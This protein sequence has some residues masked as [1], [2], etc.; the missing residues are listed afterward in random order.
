LVRFGRYLGKFEQLWVNLL[1]LCQK[2]SFI[3]RLYSWDDKHEHE[4]RKYAASPLL[5]NFSEA[6][7]MIYR[8]ALPSIS[9]ICRCR[10]KAI[11]T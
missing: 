1:R 2:V 9:L 10:S 8:F 4:H 7:P 3:P 6:Y 5:N 11:M